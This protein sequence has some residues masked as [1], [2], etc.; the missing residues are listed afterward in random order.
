MEW[1]GS[2]DVPT[3]ARLVLCA[4]PAAVFPFAMSGTN[5]GLMGVPSVITLAVFF[6]TLVPGALLFAMTRTRFGVTL[7]VSLLAITGVVGLYLAGR[8]NPI[9]ATAGYVWAMVYLGCG[10]A[11]LVGLADSVV[12]LRRM[13]SDAPEGSTLEAPN[14]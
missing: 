6:S 5:A 14:L 1:R 4:L 11:L 13:R 9:E 7:G 8:G 2:D 12:R 3:G 10:S